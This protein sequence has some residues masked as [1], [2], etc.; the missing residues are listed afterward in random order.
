MLSVI[1]FITSEKSSV[2]ILFKYSLC[3]IY[4]YY[5]IFR[6]SLS[7]FYVI[8][9]F[10]FPGCSLDISSDLPS[11]LL[12]LS[13]AHLHC[14]QMHPLGVHYSATQS[15]SFRQMA[16]MSPGSSL[17][18]TFLGPDF[19]PTKSETMRVES[20]KL[21]WQSLT[22]KFSCMLSY[23]KQSFTIVYFLNF[24]NSI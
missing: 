7:F 5:S 2:I 20:R 10:I 19:R 14:H 18:M 17:E 4:F 8:R 21:L 16:L 1:A 22:I 12:I 23:N 11:N 13:L 9:L 15:V 3:Y 24:I 6:V